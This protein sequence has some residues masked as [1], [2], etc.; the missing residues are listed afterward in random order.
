VG[1]MI[2]S[3][4]QMVV[5]AKEIETKTMVVACAA[6]EH[7]LEA[8][9]LA[10]KEKIINGI[11]VGDK[12]EIIKLLG[13]LDISSENYTILDFP[14]NEEACLESV[15]LVSSNKG[16]FLMKGLVD[17]SIILKAALNKEFGLRT[18]NR[19]SHV[20]VMEVPTHDKLIFMSDGAMN[21][22]PTLDE[23]RQ[24]IE[25]SVKIAHAL[26]I[27]RPN[28]GVIGA[29][30]KVNPKMEATLDA[31][32]LIEMNKKGDI[33]N[34]IVGGPFA[35]DNAINVEAAKHKGITDPMAGNVD[36]LIM[37]R[38]ESGNVFYKTMM[39]LANAKSAS[40]IAGAQKPIVLTSR[41]DSTISKFYSIALAALVADL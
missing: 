13:Q 38:I 2:K 9:E 32:A 20:S 19:I 29:V 35:I 28:V 12:E 23:K 36:I 1:K 5:K 27:K 37:P 25:N 10:R 8:V 4:E 33:E 6:D 26:G 31:Q 22:A 30:E 16:Y 24:I 7:V 14:N 15:K 34:C 3:I 39:F 41:A 21:I 40:V 11:L 18:R 17:T